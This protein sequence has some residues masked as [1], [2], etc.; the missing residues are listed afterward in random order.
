MNVGAFLGS[1]LSENLHSDDSVDE[2]D[3]SDENCDPWKS[4]ERFDES[5][6]ESPD[7]FA[8]AEELDEPHDSEEAEK[9]D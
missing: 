9:V 4:L 6:E 2:E 5:P 3:E 8:F 7:A 1:D